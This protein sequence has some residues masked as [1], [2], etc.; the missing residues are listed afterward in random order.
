MNPDI[1]SI[2]EDAFA[3]ALDV[4]KRAIDFIKKVL[5]FFKGESEEETVETS[6]E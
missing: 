4:I 2:W 1:P 6:E 5:A 3:N